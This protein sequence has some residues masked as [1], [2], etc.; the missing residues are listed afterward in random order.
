LSTKHIHL[1]KFLLYKSLGEYARSK[2]F[3]QNFRIFDYFANN[4]YDYIKCILSKSFAK[5]SFKAGKL[6]KLFKQSFFNGRSYVKFKNS[7]DGLD[8]FISLCDVKQKKFL[9]HESN[10]FC[11]TQNFNIGVYGFLTDTH[12]FP[13]FINFY[14]VR[15]INFDSIFLRKLCLNKKLML[16]LKKVLLNFFL[17]KFN[18]FVFKKI[19]L[20]FLLLIDPKFFNFV[21]M[22]MKSY[23]EVFSFNKK[24]IYFFIICLFLQKQVLCSSNEFFFNKR[25]KVSK[26]FYYFYRI[27]KYLV[28]KKNENLC[29]TL[30]LRRFVKFPKRFLRFNFSFSFFY[31]RK[32]L[33]KFFFSMKFLLVYFYKKNMLNANIFFDKF[34]FRSFFFINLFFSLKKTLNRSFKFF[35]FHKLFRRINRLKFKESKKAKRAFFYELRCKFR[36]TPDEHKIGPRTFFRW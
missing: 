10:F 20:Y 26:F 1:K 36:S 11:L 9:L 21:N 25:F 32:F 6:K 7:Q 17:H 18:K 8:N 23:E 16:N 5:Y 29:S 27:K 2:N 34:I 15:S 19:T 30:L 4:R 22:L 24:Y 31:F 12:S 35:D 3:I 13:K 28:Y 14:R 33:V